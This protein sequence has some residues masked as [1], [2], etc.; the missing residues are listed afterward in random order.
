DTSRGSSPTSSSRPTGTGSPPAT[1]P[2]TTSPTTANPARNATTYAPSPTATANASPNSPPKD[3]AA[4]RPKAATPSTDA[5]TFST[6]NRPTSTKDAPTSPTTS[7]RSSPTAPTPNTAT[8]EVGVGPAPLASSDQRQPNTWSHGVQPPTP[9]LPS[10][11]NATYSISPTASEYARDDVEIE[12]IGEY[13][14]V[15]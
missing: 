12:T 10:E 2:S 8:A 11:R 13:V 5:R 7:T 9:R 14:V 3:D 6:P 15:D 1:S 4:G